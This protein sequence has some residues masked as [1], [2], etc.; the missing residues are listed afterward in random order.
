MFSGLWSLMGMQSSPW[1]VTSGAAW[2]LGLMETSALLVDSRCKLHA[3]NH[4]HRG[5]ASVPDIS[6]SKGQDGHVGKSAKRHLHWEQPSYSTQVAAVKLLPC[7][8][9]LLP[10]K[11]LW[12]RAELLDGSWAAKPPCTGICIQGGEN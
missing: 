11:A 2:F 5:F 4:L 6:L 8:V 3:Y 9:S 7:R 12:L 1:L 10:S